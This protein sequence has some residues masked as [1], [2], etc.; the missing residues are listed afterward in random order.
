M[1]NAYRFRLHLL[2]N[3]FLFSLSDKSVANVLTVSA[4]SEGEFSM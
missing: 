3:L 4:Q 2:L 1:L